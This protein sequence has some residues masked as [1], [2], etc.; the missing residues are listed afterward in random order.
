M[1]RYAL[2]H[3]APLAVE[4]RA[5]RRLGRLKRV[6]LLSI[7]RFGFVRRVGETRLRTVSTFNK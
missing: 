6:S 4:E 1:I 2:T 3:L 7:L 5:Q